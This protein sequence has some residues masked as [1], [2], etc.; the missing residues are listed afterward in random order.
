[1]D[2]CCTSPYN[3]NY[4]SDNNY[5]FPTELIDFYGAFRACVRAKIAIW[6]LADCAPGE[7]EHWR[8]RARDYLGLAGART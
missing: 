6:H 4:W 1:M 8:Q 3:T 2:F 7:R 5:D